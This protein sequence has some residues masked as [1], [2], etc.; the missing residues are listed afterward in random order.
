[1]GEEIK[2]QWERK[3]RERGEKEERKRRET[4]EKMMGSGE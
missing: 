1:L 2:Y 3:R 4:D